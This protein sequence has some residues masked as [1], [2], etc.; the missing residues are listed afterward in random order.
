MRAIS[1]ITSISRVTSSEARSSARARRSCPGR[2]A[3]RS[4][5]G[6]GSR[7]RARARPRA[8]VT[9]ATRSMRTRSCARGGRSAADVDRPRRHAAAAELD[10]AAA[11]RRARRPARGRVDALLPAVRAVR[12]QAERLRRAQDLRAREVG[13]LEH[14]R[15]R[16]LADLGVGAAHDPADALRPLG[17]GDHAASSASSSRSWPSSVRSVSPA[18]A[19]RAVSRAPRM[20]R[21][22]VG[23]Q[24]AAE[25]VH[26]VVRDVDD[27][28]DR[29]HAGG[30]QR[31]P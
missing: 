13:G 9:C 31:A 1:S 16:A 30:L 5:G 24:R 14:D 23:V 20:L 3:D 15:V 11:P 19:R 29:A 12:A 17:V 18:R 25:V 7:P 4:R 2:R 22:V 6:R 26:H 8:P 10:D 27:V 28:R 21:V